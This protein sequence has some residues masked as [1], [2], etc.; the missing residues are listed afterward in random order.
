MGHYLDGRVT[1]VLGTH[2]HVQTSDARVLPGGTAYMTDVGMTGPR[3]SV[4]GV[5]T[6]IDPAPVHDRAAAA[7]RGRGG[8]GAAGRGAH[9]R[10]GR[11]GDGDRGAGRHPVAAETGVVRAT[12]R[13]DPADAR[14]RYLTWHWSL[15]AAQ[16][17]SRRRAVPRSWTSRPSWSPQGVADTVNMARRHARRAQGA[18]RAAAPRRSAT[19]PARGRAGRPS[20]ASPRRW[21]P[22]PSRSSPPRC[23][24]SGSS[25]E[26]DHLPLLERLNGSFEGDPARRRAAVRLLTP[27][28]LAALWAFG[29]YREPGR[30]IGGFNLGGVAERPDRAHVRELAAA[31]RPG[32]RAR[33]RGA[34]SP[35]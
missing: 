14:D 17:V 28:W 5:R 33:A 22:T 27:Y 23:S 3:D 20:C 29:L 16:S 24:P 26:F 2:T 30:S 32:A 8:A 9:R 7:V 4:I 35:C 13:D 6:D 25:L 34:R 18:A 31:H 19:R 11:A 21:S 12:S 1:A 10:R 15:H